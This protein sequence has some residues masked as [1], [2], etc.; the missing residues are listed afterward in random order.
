LLELPGALGI[1]VASISTPVPYLR[2]PAERI[3]RWRGRFAASQPQ[4]RV[5]IA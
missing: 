3:D 2:A 5:G 1:D 4:L